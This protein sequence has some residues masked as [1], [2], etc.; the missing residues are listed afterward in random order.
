MLLKKAGAYGP[1]A[2]LCQETLLTISHNT[3]HFAES[4]ALYIT[5]SM[6]L[7]RM[8]AGDVVLDTLSLHLGVVDSLHLPV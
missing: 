8:T 7:D 2:I 6:V 5:G 3:T 1:F 4:V